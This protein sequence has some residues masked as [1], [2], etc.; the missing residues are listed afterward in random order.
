MTLENQEVLPPYLPYFQDLV[1]VLLLL[2]LL[3]L[4][5]L[6]LLVLLQERHLPT[7]P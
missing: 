4:L 3:L 7:H 5:H 1:H 6:A 2:L